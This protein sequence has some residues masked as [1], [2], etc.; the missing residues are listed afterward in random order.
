M[1][2]QSLITIGPSKSN[3]A[4]VVP[5]RCPS[6]YL[7]RISD[8]ISLLVIQPSPF[9]NLDCDYC[10]LP[11]RSTTARMNLRIL[12]A[13][14]QNI[15]GSG[16]VRETLNVVWHAGEPLAV[17]VSYYREAFDVISAMT[18]SGVDVR[19]SFQTNAT[20]VSR[21]WCDFIHEY[22]ISIGVSID[23]PKEIHD[24]HRVTKGGR[25]T[26]DRVMRGIRLLQENDITF[27]VI[28]V[29]TAASLDFPEDIFSFFLDLGIRDLG[30][31]IEELEGSH[32]TSSLSP[33]E[34]NEKMMKFW[35]ILYK[36]SKRSNDAIRIREFEHARSALTQSPFYD[37]NRGYNKQALPLAIVSVDHSG[38]ISTFSPELLGINIGYFSDFTFGNVDRTELK[39]ILEHPE[40][41]NIGNEVY[42]GVCRCASDCEFFSLCGGG[43]PA[44]KYFEHGTFAST[45]TMFCR[46]TI[47]MP[48]A[49]LAEDLE[50]DLGLKR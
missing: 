26:F 4:N 11:S 21:P 9:C 50:Q 1:K 31:N 8:T 45:E 20:L 3:S 46:F 23:G 19:H 33:P 34:V 38:N 40:F 24:R 37:L 28:A 39:Q 14:F 48:L 16:L 6:K 43:A 41:I 32:E 7:G 18:P 47:Q 12:A 5:E 49:V 22:S 30:F 25:G 27:S 13:T 10:Y 35:Y 42:Q 15:I 36:L 44:N 2:Q 29:I 17:P